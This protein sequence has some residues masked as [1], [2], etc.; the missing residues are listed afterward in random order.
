[1]VFASRLG[2]E[3]SGVVLSAGLTSR[4]VVGA[5][6]AGSWS[7]PYEFHEVVF[8]AFMERCDSRCYPTAPHCPPR[9]YFGPIS[10]WLTHTSLYIY[11]NYLD[12]ERTRQS[13]LRPRAVVPFYM[14]LHSPQ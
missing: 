11:S 4:T 12:N 5:Y 10:L 6:F 3:A 1:M 14:E 2:L 13:D 8:A 9:S 7:Y